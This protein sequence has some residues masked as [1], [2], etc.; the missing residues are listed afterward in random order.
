MLDLRETAIEVVESLVDR[1][2]ADVKLGN[3]L[4]EYELWNRVHAY[5]LTI[6]QADD[7]GARHMIEMTGPVLARTLEPFPVLVR[8]PDGLHLATLDPLRRNATTVYWPLRRRWESR[9][10]HYEVGRNRS[11]E[12]RRSYSMTSSARPKDQRRDRQ[13]QLAGGLQVD[14]E[15]EPDRFL[16]RQ[17]AG[18]GALQDAVD[19]VGGT[20]E[21]VRHIGPI[22]HQAAIVGIL[23]LWVNRRQMRRIDKRDDIRR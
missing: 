9:S 6:T 16:D 23:P 20:A 17:V 12:W 22:G 19:V 2:L 3:R 14:D 11:L 13:P 4:L 1:G 8:T 10:P 21:I 5:R 7:V 18:L 15:I